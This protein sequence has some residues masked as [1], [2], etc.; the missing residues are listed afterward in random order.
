MKLRHSFKITLL[1]YCVLLPCVCLPCEKE[2]QQEIKLLLLTAAT[3][4]AAAAADC[5]REAGCL[6]RHSR[7]FDAMVCV[8]GCVLYPTHYDCRI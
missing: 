5:V 1:E 8:G 6:K 7:H 2:G 3:A 4:V